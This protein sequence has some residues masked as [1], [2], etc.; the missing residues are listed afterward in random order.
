MVDSPSAPP[1]VL[2]WGSALDGRRSVAALA[3]EVENTTDEAIDVEL[4]AVGSGNARSA[5]LPQAVRVNARA[6]VTRAIPVTALPVQL[7][8]ASADLLV[9]ASY[10][11]VDGVERMT[12]APTIWVEHS[13][14]FASARV[15]GQEQEARANAARGLAALTA[16]R[17]SAARLVDDSGKADAVDA[18]ALRTAQ[19]AAQLPEL[20]NP[21][22]QRVPSTTPD[23]SEV[24]DAERAEAMSSTSDELVDKGGNYKVCY[25]LGYSYIDAKMGE[26]YLIGHTST[27]AG[28]EPAR[29]MY[30]VVQNASGSTVWS[31]WL[32]SAGCS[33][34]FNHANGT[35]KGWVTTAL[36]RSASNVTINLTPTDSSG[37]LWYWQ[38][39]S[40]SGSGG[41]ITLDG[42]GADTV[43]SAAIAAA[44]TLYRSTT[45]WPSGTTSNVYVNQN[46]PGSTGGCASGNNVWLGQDNFGVY[47]GWFKFVTSHELGHVVMRALFGMP[48]NSYDNDAP[49]DL[50]QCKHVLSANQLHCLQSRHHVAS[51]QVEGWAQFFGS[52]NL[53]VG[54]QSDCT[55]VYY[56]EFKMGN[57]V[58]QPVP[59]AKAC[60]TPILWMET[61]CPATTRGV[62]WDWMNF[63]WRLDN[64]DAY[65]YADFKSVYQQACGGS[66][67]GATTTV[68]WSNTSA[69]A[70]AVFGA[71]HAKALAWAN[72]GDAFGVNH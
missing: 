11:G 17:P 49:S 10:V 4:H 69:A 28:H 59:N 26:D 47:L 61:Y 53:N 5:R 45:G 18:G 44:N 39:Y 43:S 19:I 66:C 36:Y 8:G 9:T 12:P 24:S 46:C 60:Y 41:T 2:R 42:F 32:D 65:A 15:R 63:Y 22:E 20:P 7:V 72:Q 1:I 64:K 68:K 70:S 54:S 29:Y 40:I 51:A 25:K 56:K 48:A 31:G 13:A 58:V 57:G 62:E 33:P 6:T 50:C 27:S 71:N 16:R 35:Y 23:T 3:L 67:S 34:Y 30:A 21:A 37:F 38:G 52:T 14:G 55:F